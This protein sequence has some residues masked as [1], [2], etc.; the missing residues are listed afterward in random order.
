[1]ARPAEAM[2]LDYDVVLRDYIRVL[3]R[4][5]RSDAKRRSPGHDLRTC[6]S[7]GARVAFTLDP[8]GTWFSCS[9]C[10]SFA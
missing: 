8:N 3:T 6:A 2:E 5:T 10:G 7:C 4:D 9:R 1:M